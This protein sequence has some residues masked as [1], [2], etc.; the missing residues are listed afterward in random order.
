MKNVEPAWLVRARS[1]LNT[2]EAPGTANNPTILGWAKAA[3]IKVLGIVYNADSVPWCGV[4]VTECLRHAGVNLGKMKVGVRAMAWATW[5]DPVKLDQLA[6]GTILVFQR[7]AGGHVGFYVGEDR[8]HFHVLGGNQ[9]DRVSIMR[10]EKA[11]CVAARWPSDQPLLGHP[12][13][14]TATA[15]VAVSRNEA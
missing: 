10:L 15:G 13:V 8:T 1:L 9:G 2:R 14:M 4:F 11:R 12:V 3:G 6:P 7:P 5:G